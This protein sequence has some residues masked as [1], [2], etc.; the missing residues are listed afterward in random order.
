MNNSTEYGD[1]A[2]NK[3]LDNKEGVDTSQYGYGSIPINTIFSGMNIHKS[4]L[5]WCELQG[6][7]WFWHTA[8]YKIYELNQVLGVEAQVKGAYRYMM[9]SRIHELAPS[10]VKLLNDSST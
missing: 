6:Y 8:I 3:F 2:D 9:D 5:F 10:V 7:Y 1:I 4:Q